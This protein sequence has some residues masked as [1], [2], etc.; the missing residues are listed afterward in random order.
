MVKRPAILF[1]MIFIIL[2]STCLGLAEPGWAESGH[3]QG[4]TRQGLLR[5]GFALSGIDGKVSS[6]GFQPVNTAKPVPSEVEGMA[7]PQWFFEL[8]LDVVDDRVVVRKGTSLQLLPSATLQR[9]IN[10]MQIRPVGDYR[11]WGRITKYKGKNFIFPIYFLP[12][13]KIKQPQSEIQQEPNTQ[14]QK[15]P[16][17]TVIEKDDSDFGEL[18][19]A[20][21]NINDP[22]DIL[23][24]PQEVIEKLRARRLEP[25]K[26]PDD[27]TGRE[28]EPIVQPARIEKRDS[29]WASAQTRP[30]QTFRQDTIL[31]DRTAFLVGQDDGQ[32]VFVLD[33][34]GRSAP[35]ISLRLLPCEAL[36]LTEQ[37]QSAELEQLTFKIAGIMTKYKDQNYLLL[38]RATKVYDHG[39]FAR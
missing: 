7:V 21:P 32:F 16:D 25:A 2:I 15:P 27:Y 35:K 13:S 38:Q 29:G 36:E 31:A 33:A 6:T 4:P 17:T 26:L 9:I 12:L 3:G 28:T 20:G 8:D 22:N 39:N 34:L 14:E 1:L 10:N 30:S 24:V 18:G 11:L 5:D 37:R 23:A 19:R